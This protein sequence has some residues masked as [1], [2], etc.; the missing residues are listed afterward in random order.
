ME[1]VIFNHAIDIAAAIFQAIMLGII[2]YG[3]ALLQSK[4][5]DD[6]IK[7]ALNSVQNAVNIT[8]NELNQMFVK[9]WKAAGGGKLTAAQIDEL[10]TRSV[11]LIYEKLTDPT[12]KLLDA[13]YSN[14]DNLIQSMIQAKIDEI[15]SQPA[16]TPL[17]GN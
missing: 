1:Q 13:S 8:V 16:S 7:N 2:A 15:K 9:D 3:F 5:K 10:K 4:I 12:I 11:H 17:P 6:K 14:L